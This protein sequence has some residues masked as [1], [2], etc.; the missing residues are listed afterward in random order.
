MKTLT[1]TPMNA[2]IDP[3]YWVINGAPDGAS[4]QNDTTRL[5]CSA[6]R[7]ADTNIYQ[8]HV[9]N[10]AKLFSGVTTL[11][12]PTTV[13]PYT[14]TPS[15]SW[16][17]LA[18]NYAYTGDNFVFVNDVNGFS[19][20]NTLVVLEGDS[21]PN[22]PA[23][24][25]EW[26]QVGTFGHI[27]TIQN[28][29]TKDSGTLASVPFP[30]SVGNGTDKPF[31][32]SASAAT[33]SSAIKGVVTDWTWDYVQAIDTTAKTITLVS[34][35][36]QAGAWAVGQQVVMPSG[37]YVGTISAV[38]TTTTIPIPISGGY[39][40]MPIVQP[41]VTVTQL[42]FANSSATSLWQGA[43]SVQS[44]LVTTATIDTATIGASA[45]T[46]P[47]IP[48]FSIMAGV[49]IATS[50]Y[51]IN[52]SSGITGATVSGGAPTYTIN[53]VSTNNPVF[54][55]EYITIYGI[56]GS[57]TSLNFTDALVTAV[58]GSSGAWTFTLGNI[59]TATVGTANYTS[60]S[61][62]GTVFPLGTTI[63]GV[64]W[65][66]TLGKLTVTTS[67]AAIRTANIASVTYFAPVF[68]ATVASD[69]SAGFANAAPVLLTTGG[70]ATT[71]S[72]PITNTTVSVG[73]S[74]YGWNISN[75]DIERGAGSVGTITSV[76]TGVIANISNP[77]ITGITAT[78]T[79]GTASLTLS[80]ANQI[81]PGMVV[82]GTNIPQ[83]S[84]V[85]TVN[86]LTEVITI[87]ANV[88]GALSS[89]SV[90]FS[91]T[92][93]YTTAT[94]ASSGT[95]RT[96]T[97]STPGAGIKTGDSIT[98]TTI[99]GATN[100]NTYFVGTWTIASASTTAGTTTVTFTGSG[101]VTITSTSFAGAVQ[102]VLPSCYNKIVT[103]YTN[104]WLP[105]LND[106]VS[107][108]GLAAGTTV[109]WVNNNGNTGITGGQY[110]LV[111]N[112]FSSGA[113]S[114]VL[115]DTT[116]TT[117]LTLVVTTASQTITYIDNTPET[118][119]SG[120]PIMTFT[121]SKAYQ[122]TITTPAGNTYNA[123]IAP[124]PPFYSTV[125]PSP[126]GF[127]SSVGDTTD[128]PY[129][130]TGSS[131]W[132]HPYYK[133]LM[134]PV[135][136]LNWQS[137]PLATFVSMNGTTVTCDDNSKIA[138]YYAANPT[139]AYLAF[140]G[141][142]ALKGGGSKWRIN[143]IPTG[144]TNTFTIDS[145]TSSSY[146]VQ[147][148]AYPNGDSQNN[149]YAWEVNTNDSLAWIVPN[150]SAISAP[151]F[152]GTG[153]GVVTVQNGTIG[154]VHSAGTTVGSYLY[155]TTAKRWIGSNTAADLEYLIADQIGSRYS[156]TLYAD[157][158]GGVDT[159]F[160]VAPAPAQISATLTLKV[161]SGQ[162]YLETNAGS[163][164]SGV[165]GIYGPVSGV[166][167]GMLVIGAGI[168]TGTVVTSVVAP[169]NPVSGG[170]SGKI[171]IS[172]APTATNVS[173][174]VTFTSNVMNLAADITGDTSVAIVG[175]GTNQE[176]VLL[177]GA[178]QS[179]DG[180]VH[181]VPI[182]W[183]LASGS[184]FRFDHFVG[185]PVYT[186]NVLCY[187]NPLA[188]DHGVDTPVV[189]S[190]DISTTTSATASAALIAQNI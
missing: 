90:G 50:S 89:T 111:S 26:G 99:A 47:S 186:P 128:G 106:A 13:A 15:S 85:L 172:N 155:S 168:P 29:P 34:T 14:Y 188:N 185:E 131:Y 38:G 17:L 3:K 157:V 138:A 79:S 190:P 103:S 48:P 160:I 32:I 129:G 148:N 52:G 169:V 44:G 187:N 27:P 77:T 144:S 31:W 25:S 24:Y 37:N 70:Y 95:T 117:G 62:L 177:S 16:A 9:D 2:K 180:S 176:A 141:E 93:T 82:Y 118:L 98:M 64:Y 23:F 78:A 96:L 156:T 134:F 100:W 5:S 105:T 158:L 159:S 80:S 53:T 175:A 114:Y 94:I 33:P 41:G 167:K 150:A 92:G 56:T 51:I 171:Y 183:T 69:V 59:T 19:P 30:S 68:A 184:S 165:T 61:V 182:V 130:T 115:I 6:V 73:Q 55:G 71:T 116:T 8:V 135:N 123:S 46:A 170:S 40:A 163:G 127:A 28:N 39:S 161:T 174:S 139:T 65:D 147:Q 108:A 67:Q 152:N 58:G 102:G 145:T 42:T 162:A 140:R 81:I 120:Q 137:T 4:A 142:G 21:Q 84:T 76:S 49:P 43:M 113:G 11:S 154:G 189:G 12:I 54:L 63:T 153:P 179:L 87:S 122:G 125:D 97:F 74:L 149:I 20:S 178:Y 107:S 112:A 110:F 124:M 88:T 173:Q 45:F 36:P 164:G 60:G 121:P 1:A 72:F 35:T 18:P 7:T 83:G 104:S 119:A 10:V 136:I 101:S 146:A 126:Y 181:N 75:P 166:S 66:T 91:S 109:T 132:F 57:G 133:T 86:S 22:S 143:G 151:S